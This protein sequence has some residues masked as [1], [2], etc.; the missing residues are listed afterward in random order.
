MCLPRIFDN[1]APFIASA[2]FLL[3]LLPLTFA[4]ADSVAGPCPSGCTCE[5]FSMAI[6][7]EVA[8][9]PDFANKSLVHKL[10]VN[11]HQIYSLTNSNFTEFSQLQHLILTSGQITDI[12]AG[13]FDHIKAT[14]IL[15]D[16]SQN[17]ISKIQQNVFKDLC[18]LNSLRLN[19]NRLQILHDN[20]FVN[21]PMLV[22]LELKTN[23]I[24]TIEIDT[25]KNV[26]NLANLNLFN[27]GLAEVPFEALSSLKGLKVLIVSDNKIASLPD[28]VDAYLPNLED[29]QLARNKLTEVN[30]F[31]N[32]SSVLM[33][34]D[35]SF[36]SIRHINKTTWRNVPGIK[37]LSLSGTSLNSINVGDFEGLNNL[38]TIYLDSMPDLEYIGSNAFSD[39]PNISVI[40]ITLNPILVTIN[41]NAFQSTN[42]SIV[43]LSENSLTKI[44][45]NLLQWKSVMFIN[46]SGNP[47]NC[48]CNVTW[49]LN[50][51][52][53]GNNKIAKSAFAE[54]TCAT[55]KELKDRKLLNLGISDLRCLP[56]IFNHMSRLITGTSVAVVVLV[57]FITLTTIIKFRTHIVMSVNRYFLYRRLRSD[58]IF[59][60]G[61]DTVSKLS[62]DSQHE[63]DGTKKWKHIKTEA[64]AFSNMI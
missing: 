7:N 37:M 53:Y 17:N 33:N 26:S 64:I 42:V 44:P 18:Q 19:E 39:L 58:M 1:M 14:V 63:I 20:T 25:F 12:D 41:E 55:P 45:Q 13:T 24:Q 4:T 61:N 3:A 59:T 6:C 8:V 56:M 52:T 30:V 46:V 51:S 54:L 29:I 32:V 34:I 22:T 9:I 35:L 40:S 5:S 47:V 57:A 23:Q 16:L 21:L 48:D 50:S 49:M 31:L 38:H 11:N 10:V 28:S 2:N 27:N 43:L 60:A 15:I 62:D 36:N